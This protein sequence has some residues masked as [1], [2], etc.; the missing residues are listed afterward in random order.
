MMPILHASAETKDTVAWRDFKQHVSNSNLQKLTRPLVVTD[1]TGGMYFR[2][3]GRTLCAIPELCLVQQDS[4]EVRQLGC[5]HI[6]IIYLCAL[7]DHADT[8]FL[9]MLCVHAVCRGIAC[10]G[11]RCTT[12]RNDLA[13]TAGYAKPIA[14]I[15]TSWVHLERRGKIEI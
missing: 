11:N 12:R 13:G 3:G 1:R 5:L 2:R 10:A 7:Y 15:P 4:P 14:L 9:H 6:V 8:V